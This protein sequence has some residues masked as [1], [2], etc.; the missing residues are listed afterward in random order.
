MMKA[1]ITC[2]LEEEKA[3]G[4][5]FAHSTSLRDFHPAEA[6][7]EAAGIVLGSRK[8]GVRVKSGKYTVILGPQPVTEIMGNL[9]VP[10][11]S[12]P[13]IYSSSS[14]FTGRLGDKLTDF[15]ISIFDDGTLP[16]RTGTRRYTC[17]GI[18]TGRTDLISRGYLTGFL[19]DSYYSTLL[20]GKLRTFVPRNGFR[21]LEGARNCSSWVEISP[22][23]L[24]IESRS[25]LP[26]ED[27]IKSVE[28]GLYLGRLWYTY[29]IS[30]LAAGDFT[31]TV[32]ADSWIIRNGR[33]ESPLLP[34]T[35]RIHENFLD[36]L[37]RI[38][39]TSTEKRAV[40]DWGATY[41]VAAPQILIEDV[42][43]EEIGEAL[44]LD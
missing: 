38:R 24:V 15:E 30:G 33:L 42:T 29:P 25:E 9:L 14:P 26:S 16:G 28:Y 36:I 34:N 12:L 39:A 6:G 18:P 41:E 40:L 22:T 32:T 10:S 1:T 2:I 7:K 17:E 31:S 20:G 13:S 35:L 3:R 19:A 4:T 37:K 44:L 43:V 8:G 23:N 5:G 27:L 11:L 21:M